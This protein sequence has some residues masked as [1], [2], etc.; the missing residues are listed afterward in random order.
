MSWRGLFDDTSATETTGLFPENG[1]R[2]IEFAGVEF[3]LDPDGALRTVV[4]HHFLFNPGI[5]IPREA[6]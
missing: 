3:K 2:V 1:D 5:P 4:P 6:S